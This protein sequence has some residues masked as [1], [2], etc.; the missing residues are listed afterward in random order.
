MKSSLKIAST[1]LLL[2]YSFLISAQKPVLLKGIKGSA[3]IVGDISPNQ[4]KQQAM[5]EA[6]T[7]ALK[8]A[9]IVEHINSYQMLFSSYNKNDYS[10]FFSSDIQS[11]IQGAVQSYT[12]TSEKTYFNTDKQI[13]C[14]VVMDIEVIKYDT[15]PDPAFTVNTE[16]IKA[17]YNNGDNLKF[18]VKTSIDCYLHVF[19]I[20][21][22][23]V[24]QFFPNN[25]EKKY[26]LEKQKEYSFPMAEID[27]SLGNDKKKTETN[28]LIFVFTKTD[29]PYM[30]MNKERITSNENVFS[31]IY[32]IPPDQRKVEYYVLTIQN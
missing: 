3:F 29:I 14:D 18:S 10:Q 32:S 15:K 31:W 27:Y 1:L 22:S 5:N 21:D 16:G 23:E 28:R 7:Q 26:H 30:K 4:A 13:V 25:Y 6:K 19:N 17:V 11:E 12:V 2:A 8:D 20:T 24:S 9:G